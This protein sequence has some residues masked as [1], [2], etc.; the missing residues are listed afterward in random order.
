MSEALE[1]AILRLAEAARR[2]DE[3]WRL[4]SPESE[5][6]H[7]ITI[8]H[9]GGDAVA[10]ARATLD[11]DDDGRSWREATAI[12]RKAA[13]GSDVSRQ[14]G[15][16]IMGY[17]VFDMLGRSPYVTPEIYIY[18]PPEVLGIV[19]AIRTRPE[20]PTLVAEEFAA[21]RFRTE[22]PPWPAEAATA[23]L[24]WLVACLQRVTE[25]GLGVFWEVRQG[26][27]GPPT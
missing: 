4:A 22:V 13:V 21:R 25:Q 10:A 6:A 24:A 17:I 8:H 26:A 9:V 16:I 15:R 5:T 11:F 18:D 2:H 20:L 27:A 23:P 19:T 14:T 1:Q 12:L 7:A 3:E